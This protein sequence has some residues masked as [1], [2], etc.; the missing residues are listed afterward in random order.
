MCRIIYNQLYVPRS[1]NTM[2][3]ASISFCVR[4]D[5]AVQKRARESKRRRSDMKARNEKIVDVNTKAIQ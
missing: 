2:L 4:S 3:F 5:V 1:R